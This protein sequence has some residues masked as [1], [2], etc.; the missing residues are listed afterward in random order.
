MEIPEAMP[1]EARE[2]DLSS[3]FNLLLDL[4]VSV[5]F[6]LFCFSIPT[7]NK[8]MGIPSLIFQTPNGWFCLALLLDTSDVGNNVISRTD[9]LLVMS[10]VSSFQSFL[11]HKKEKNL[12]IGAY[13][14]VF[15]GLKP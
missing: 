12:S 6:Y 3:S 11:I 1:Y 7:L 13:S 10:H 4:Y 8:A 9:A 14:I 15:S 2:F 5:F